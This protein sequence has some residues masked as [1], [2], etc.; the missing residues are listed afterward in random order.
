MEKKYEVLKSNSNAYRIPN[1]EETVALGPVSRQIVS[2]IYGPK[3]KHRTSVDVEHS[4]WDML[5]IM[6]L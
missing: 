3:K 5:V 4:F 6:T 1:N 2:C